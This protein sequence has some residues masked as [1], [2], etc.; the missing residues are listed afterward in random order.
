MK[1]I[2][3]GFILAANTL[4]FGCASVPMAPDAEDLAAKAFTVSKDKAGIYIYRD[5]TFGAAIKMPVSMDEKLLGQTASKTYFFK[6]V[7]P[8]NHVIKSLTENTSTLDL[9]AEAGKIYYVWQEVK[10][11]AFQAGSKLQL[12]SEE[13][14]QKGV[15]SCKLIKM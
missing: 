13:K 4:L 12:V 3:L 5:E 10:M 14:G 8:G 9:K 15:K 7:K 2:I 11:G 6:E 1:K